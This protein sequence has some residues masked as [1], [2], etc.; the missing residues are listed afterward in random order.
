MKNRI[1]FTIITLF[2]LIAAPVSAQETP[3]QNSELP[4]QAQVFVKKHFKAPIHHAI[5]DIEQ[6][7]ISYDVTLED[8]TEIE[9]DEAGRWKEVSGKNKAIPTSFIQ[10]QILDYVKG[11][12]P[13]ETINKIELSTYEYEVGLSNGMDLVFDVSGAFVKVD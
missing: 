13:K 2:L 12:Y 9:F 5:K 7:K 6:K 11:K 8:G 4:A 3:I 1:L 10:K